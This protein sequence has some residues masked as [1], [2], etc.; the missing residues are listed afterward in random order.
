VAQGRNNPDTAPE[1]PPCKCCKGTLKLL[2]TLAPA[3]NHPRY[4]IFECKGCSHIEWV[5]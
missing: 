4:W 2:T 1:P 3:G 5:E